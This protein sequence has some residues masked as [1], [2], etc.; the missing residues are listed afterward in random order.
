MSIVFSCLQKSAGFSDGDFRDDG[1]EFQ[2]VGPETAN[3]REP[4]VFAAN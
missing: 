3:P 4:Y 2:H 1:S